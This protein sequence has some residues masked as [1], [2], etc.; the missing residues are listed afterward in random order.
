MLWKKIA[1][2]EFNYMRTICPPSFE[3]S[4]HRVRRHDVVSTALSLCLITNN[5]S[6]IFQ[7]TVFMKI[8]LLPVLV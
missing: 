3:P 5:P 7:H 2:E 4:D 1:K 8:S 6:I